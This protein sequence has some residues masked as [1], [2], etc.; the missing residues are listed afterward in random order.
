MGTVTPPRFSTGTGPPLQW[1]CVI[2]LPFLHP[3]SAGEVPMGLAVA[4]ENN[5]AISNVDIGEDNMRDD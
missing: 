2:L 5:K 3:H 1:H 4:G